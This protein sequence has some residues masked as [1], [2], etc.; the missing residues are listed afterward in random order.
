MARGHCIRSSTLLSAVATPLSGLADSGSR[1]RLWMWT[2]CS[3]REL[4]SVQLRCQGCQGCSSSALAECGQGPRRAD[5]VLSASPGDR[6]GSDRVSNVWYHVFLCIY[7]DFSYRLAW[8]AM[9]SPGAAIAFWSALFQTCSILIS[10]CFKNEY[11]P[12]IRCC[13][14]QSHLAMASNVL[15]AAHDSAGAE[16]AA[17][18]TLRKDPTARSQ[19]GASSTTTPKAKL[20]KLRNVS[21]ADDFSAQPPQSPLTNR[22]RLKKGSGSA[23]PAPTPAPVLDSGMSVH[24]LS[25]S[26]LP[27]REAHVK[28]NLIFW[29]SF[30]LSILHFGGI[31]PL[32]VEVGLAVEQLIYRF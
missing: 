16:G 4:P 2:A 20:V 13:S 27:A 6:G 15:H 23:P 22:N 7:F 9:R 18:N 21:G 3:K 14:F 32:P 5:P 1:L 10:C 26:T 12:T 25:L 28:A 24:S 31:T 11:S 8:T 17:P 19:L 30:E 29:S